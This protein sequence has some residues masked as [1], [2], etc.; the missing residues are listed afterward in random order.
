[1]TEVAEAVIAPEPA[2]AADPPAPAPEPVVAPAFD[3]SDIST[4]PVQAQA[5]IKALRVENSTN[6]TKATAADTARQETMDAIAKA[7][8]LKGDDDPAA[9][10][11][12]AAEERDAAKT[13][14]KN[15]AV[16]NAILR[17]AAKQGA[18]PESLTDSRSFMRQ[19]EAIDP[20]ADDF[21]EKVEG[22][23]KAALEGNPALKAQGAPVVAPAR[24]GGPVG[25]GA[26][27]P[28]QL[29]RDD[30]KGMTPDEIIKAKED[31]QLNTLLGITQ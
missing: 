29:K 16:E 17:M 20:A 19:L 25:G 27:I 24:S 26:N 18:N 13:V 12:T 1:M 9:A 14:A 8:G 31:G 21:A 11:K 3:P 23:I 30:L 5:Y 28:G 15:L 10:A 4:L 22:A 2:A 6:R 7:L